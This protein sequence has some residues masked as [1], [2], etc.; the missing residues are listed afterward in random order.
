M[1]GVLMNYPG[2]QQDILEEFA[3]WTQRL[4]DLRQGAGFSIIRRNGERGTYSRLGRAAAGGRPVRLIVDQDGILYQ[5]AAD[6]SIKTGVPPGTLYKILSG[7]QG[8]K[9]A[10]GYTFRYADA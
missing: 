7:W 2:M 8:R 5:G 6:A 4:H 9:S 10:R 1:V 3:E